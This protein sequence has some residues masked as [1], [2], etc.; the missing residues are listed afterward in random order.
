MEGVLA[1]KGDDI[2]TKHTYEKN[3]TDN[4]GDD[5]IGGLGSDSLRQ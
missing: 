4:T 2:Q 5:G 3:H 1:A